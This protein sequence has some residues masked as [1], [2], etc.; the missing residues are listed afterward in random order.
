[1][2]RSVPLFTYIS[3]VVTLGSVTLVIYAIGYGYAALPGP[4]VALYIIFVLV[5]ILL[6]Y[7]EGLQVAILALEHI[8]PESFADEYPRASKTQQVVILNTMI[9]SC[10]HTCSTKSSISD[11]A[12]TLVQISD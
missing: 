2:L 5:L 10:I 7:L 1:M 4:P 12:Y 3:I 6:A 8:P 9:V 11:F